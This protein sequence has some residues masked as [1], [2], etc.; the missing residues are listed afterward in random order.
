MLRRVL[1]D[2]DLFDLFPTLSRSVRGLTSQW[3][4]LLQMIHSLPVVTFTQLLPHQPRH[5]SLDPLLSDDGVLGSFERG[6]VLVID[7]VKG[8]GDFGLIREK[9]RGFWSGHDCDLKFL[10]GV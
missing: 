2:I 5:H 1:S 8:G 4:A 10:E 9:H 7:A 3:P 6:G